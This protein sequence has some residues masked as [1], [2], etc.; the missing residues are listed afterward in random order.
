MSGDG[1]EV[2]VA[3]DTGDPLEIGSAGD[4]VGGV[5]VERGAGGNARGWVVGW[6]A[7]AGRVEEGVEAAGFGGGGEGSGVGEHI[8]RGGD[9]G[10]GAGG[11]DFDPV[12]E[13]E[14]AGDEVGDGLFGVLG[15]ECGEKRVEAGEIAGYCD[16]VNTRVESTEER[17]HGAAARAA[18]GS[19]AVGV[20]FGTGEEIVNG[21]DAVPDDDAGGSIAYERGLEA[22]F[23][24]LAGGG[25][26]EGLRGVGGVGV[27]EALALADGV[28]GEDGEAIAGEGAGE[29]VVG[30]LAGEAVAG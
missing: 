11:G 19:D 17:G 3:A 8:L 25:F 4:R 15:P 26:E 27:L 16:G 30:G 13:I 28:V 1:A 24:V 9:D 22:G 2:A 7:C 10:V 20:D 5:G 12:R 14:T 29:V 23:A 21:A 6:C 18:E